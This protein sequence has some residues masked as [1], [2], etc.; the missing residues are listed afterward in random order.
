MGGSEDSGVPRRAA[1]S[2]SALGVQSLEGW[3][4]PSRGLEGRRPS[5]RRFLLREAL[6][7][8]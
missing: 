5:S 4:A 3:I 2:W 7:P 8:T 1:A 6:T